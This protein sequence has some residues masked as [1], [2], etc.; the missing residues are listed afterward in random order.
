MLI[1][2][3]GSGALAQNGVQTL[4]PEVDAALARA[5]V[6]R[7]ALAAIVIDAAPAMNGKSAPLL[8]YRANAPVNPASVMKL[9]TTYAG[10]E[11]LGPTYT[12]TTPVYVDGTI[13]D[14]VLQGNLII[15]GKG[16]PKLVI[17][18]LW[19]LLRRV[20]SLGIKTISGD[21]F[22]DRSASGAAL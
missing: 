3:A 16:D 6:P 21:I 15:Q 18:R 4:P 13:K 17:E 9:V 5:K 14:G 8:A 19:L 1:S 10:I 22:L 20:Q 11:L 7:E 12:W 2:F